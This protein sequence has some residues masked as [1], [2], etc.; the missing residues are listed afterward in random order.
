VTSRLPGCTI[1]RYSSVLPTAANWKYGPVSAGIKRLGLAVAAVFAMGFGT[2][3]VLSYLIPADTVRERVKA[4]IQ[5]VT[6]LD[7]VLS[8]DV[9]VSLFPTGNVR[10]N[11]VSLGDQRADAPA[12]TVEELVVRLRTLPLLT[13]QI[14]IADVTLVRPTIT[15]GFA[16]DGS[17]NWS[18]HVDTLARAL[19]PS[20]DRVK[21]FSEIRI[22]DGTVVLRND[23]QRVV[24]TL[25]NVEFALAWPA[26]SKS[27]A[28]TGRFAWHDQ[29]IDATLSLTDFVAAL[30]GD[31]SGFKLRLSGAPL[32]LAYDGYIS[33][34]P[35]LRM[36]GA[37]SAD[38]ASLRDTLRWA[39]QWTA[40][41]GGFGRF[42]LKAQTNISGRTMS[43]SAVNIELDG[44]VGEGV[45]TFGGEGRQLL[46]G[47][48]ASDAIDLT[49]YVS[50]FRLLAN[51][52]W[53]RQPITLAGLA[54]V[55]IDLRLSAGR[56]TLGNVKLGRTA[57][58]ANLRRGHLTMAI[59]ESQAFGGEAS[60]TFGLAQS[61]SGAAVKVQMKLS[62]IDLQAGLGELMGVRKLEGK[63]ALVVDLASAGNSVY[64]LMQGLDGSVNLTS[65]KGTIAGLSLEQ[66]LKRFERAPL[67]TR[68]DFRSGK[69][70]YEALSLD[71]KVTQ[72]TAGIQEMRMDAPALRVALAGSASVP[73]RELDLKGVASLVTGRDAAPSFELP[74]LI[75]GPWDSPLVLPDA[76]ALFNRAG[77]TAP[78]LDAVRSRFKRGQPAGDTAT[79]PAGAM[80]SPPLPPR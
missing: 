6:G 24:E 53:S 40:P 54:G 26:I 60:G 23:A 45:L 71:L 32:K 15:I 22:S 29:P 44:N 69:T 21:S 27:F 78:L 12:L 43:L 31:R 57:L 50:T 72:G 64:E 4:Q 46:Q 42:A 16:S 11:G 20:P 48:L 13:G 80:E 14:E 67:A 5:A 8:G 58:A 52:E 51:S 3:L 33:H 63:G 19:Q 49:S 74:F 7:P 38:T 73:A 39:S 59:G 2:L 18:G 66:L 55:D 30:T 9:A 77:A 70:P 41:V 36:E 76:Q 79:P 28:A 1:A 37:L 47:T 25:T 75:T 17:S 56:M 65:K 62:D 34:R 61:D 68:G 10:F 35:T